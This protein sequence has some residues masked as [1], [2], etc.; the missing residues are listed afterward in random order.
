MLEFYRSQKTR[1]HIILV[2]FFLINLKPRETF[3]FKYL[4]MHGFFHKSYN[5]MN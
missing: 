2:I 1:T 5:A 3:V 4:Y